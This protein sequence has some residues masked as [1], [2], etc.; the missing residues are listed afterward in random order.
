MDHRDILNGIFSSDMFLAEHEICST[1][2]GLLL[3][4]LVAALPP[5][6]SGTAALAV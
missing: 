1:R 3:A 5:A 2:R 4:P 6:L